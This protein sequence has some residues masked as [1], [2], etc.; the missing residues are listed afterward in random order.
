MSELRVYCGGL[1]EVCRRSA[2]LLSAGLI[3]EAGGG[4]TFEVSVSSKLG[5]RVKLL[6]GAL[7]EAALFSAR[8]RRQRVSQTR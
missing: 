6:L 4:F 8:Y 5:E 7:L 1:S 3:S 2:G